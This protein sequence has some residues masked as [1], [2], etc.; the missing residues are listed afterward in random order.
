MF[1]QMLPLQMP[2]CDVK[3]TY[4]SLSAMPP[5]SPPTPRLH[6][7]SHILIGGDLSLEKKTEQQWNHKF[8]EHQTEAPPD[9]R[10]T[11]LS[12]LSPY[13]SRDCRF[14]ALTLLYKSQPQSHYLS[15][16]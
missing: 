5:L 3:V 7:A 1:P 16:T 14:P 9:C 2:L 12:L 15:L 4:P 10:A 13:L 11:Y 8:L 6:H